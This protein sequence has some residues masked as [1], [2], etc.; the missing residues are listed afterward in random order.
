MKSMA[1]G[2]RLNLESS[3]LQEVEGAGL[4][5]PNSNHW[6]AS[7]DHLISIQT[8]LLL[9]WLRGFLGFYLGTEE[10]GHLL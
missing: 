6:A 2:Y 8:P 7:P 4:K 9:S 1:V 10:A 5:V 3:V